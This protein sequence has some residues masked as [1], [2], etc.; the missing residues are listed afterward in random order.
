[1]AKGLQLIAVLLSYG[2]ALA[3]CYRSARCSSGL[4]NLSLAAGRD[5]GGLSLPADRSA[6]G[7]AASVALPVMRT[8]L[9]L[10]ALLLSGCSLDVAGA[11]QQL[12]AD[13]H[14]R[15]GY[16]VVP[17]E[18][19]PAIPEDPTACYI[20]RGSGCALMEYGGD[21]C[22]SRLSTAWRACNGPA[23]EVAPAASGVECRTTLETCPP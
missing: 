18:P 20:V 1:M 13:M 12:D 5:G 8:L 6:A 10:V 17:G 7:R 22:T 15:C 4:P 11:G 2:N 23:I 21:P 16:I 9:V 14:P 3:N 19:I